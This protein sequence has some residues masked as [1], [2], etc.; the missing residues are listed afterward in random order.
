MKSFKLFVLMIAA[1]FV[2]CAA[3]PKPVPKID[4]KPKISVKRFV[5]TCGMPIESYF[6]KQVGVKVH[7][8][9]K[10]MGIDDLLSLVWSGDMSQQN[11]DGITLLA[12]MYANHLNNIDPKF[13][14]MVKLLK[15]DSY[16]QKG[17]ETFVAFYQIKRKAK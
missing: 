4:N 17:V 1:I 15:I 13:N 16:T 11:L 5:A 2:S 7:R 10:C 6:I 8:H 12:V 9:K 3:T 14:H